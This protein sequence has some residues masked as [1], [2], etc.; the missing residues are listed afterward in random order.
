LAVVVALVAAGHSRWTLFDSA[1]GLFSLG[2]LVTS[3]RASVAGLRTAMLWVVAGAGGFSVAVVAG[4]FLQLWSPKLGLP[5]PM[6]T[7]TD[8]LLP[9][10]WVIGTLVVALVLHLVRRGRE[11]KRST[12]VAKPALAELPDATVVLSDGPTIAINVP[13]TRKD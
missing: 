2:L 8:V 6:D 3:I 7:L 4:Y 12:P 5:S 9:S 13:S 11:V 1:L 10:T